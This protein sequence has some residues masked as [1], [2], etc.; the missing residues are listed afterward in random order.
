MAKVS[1]GHVPDDKVYSFYYDDDEVVD[2]DNPMINGIRP[3][4]LTNPTQITSFS[5]KSS[6]PTSPA[7]T[8]PKEDEDEKE[9]EEEDLNVI[10]IKPVK[11]ND[12]PIKSKSRLGTIKRNAWVR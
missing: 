6:V 3:P 8:L 1:P 4:S 7:S 9:D 2:G 11:Q 10:P 5:D 12:I